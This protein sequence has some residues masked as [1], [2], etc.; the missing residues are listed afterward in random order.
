MA[1]ICWFEMRIRGTKENCCAFANSGF[2]C[3]DIHV[4]DKR[5]TDDDFMIYVTGTC[6]W[7]I[8]RSLVNIQHG[9]SL[10]QKAKEFNIKIEAY[11]LCADGCCERFHYKEAEIIEERSMAAYYTADEWRELPISCEDRLQYQK[12][13]SGNIYSLRGSFRENFRFETGA[14]RPVFNFAMSFDE[15]KGVKN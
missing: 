1:N 5:G 15:L 9:K 7:S 3:N 13:T 6:R 11:G 8:K 10:A 2:F 12:G 14:E 4:I